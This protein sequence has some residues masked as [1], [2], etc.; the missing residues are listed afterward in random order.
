MESNRARRPATAILILVLVAV[1]SADAPAASAKRTYS[2]CRDSVSLRHA[3][4]GVTI[5]YL[6]RGD[7]VIVTLY[8]RRHRWAY[9]ISASGYGWLLTRSLCRRRT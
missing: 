2:V 1:L 5:G 9:A 8:A 6:H 3:P 7:R 4:A